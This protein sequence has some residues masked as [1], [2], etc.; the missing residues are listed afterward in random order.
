MPNKKRIDELSALIDQ[1]YRLALELDQ[2]MAAYLLSMA[3]L[4]VAETIEGKKCK[5]G[6]RSNLVTH[7]PLQ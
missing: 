5:K 7:P 4:E 1:T 6:K 3:S 2:T